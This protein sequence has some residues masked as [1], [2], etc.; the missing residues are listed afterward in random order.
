MTQRI[1]DTI[2]SLGLQVQCPGTSVLRADGTA[3][4]ELPGCSL[5]HDLHEWVA[6][7]A[8]LDP[9]I[10]RAVDPAVGV[11]ARPLAA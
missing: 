10:D 9:A 4:C 7:D 3:E 5:P 2:L 11:V 8:D 1:T 6:T